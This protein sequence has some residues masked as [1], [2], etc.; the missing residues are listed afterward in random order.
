M[1][2]ETVDSAL[3]LDLNSDFSRVGT[4]IYSSHKYI[5]VD[6]VEGERKTDINRAMFTLK[7]EF[8]DDGF[9]SDTGGL[10][11]RHAGPISEE[12]WLRCGTLLES[13]MFCSICGERA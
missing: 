10:I 4:G 12:H 11:Y 9:P 5:M 3:R 13:G 8:D 6:G 2:T 1:D 7:A